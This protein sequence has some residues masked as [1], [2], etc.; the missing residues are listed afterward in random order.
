MKLNLSNLYVNAF[1]L[2]F[3]CMLHSANL[4][5]QTPPQLAFPIDCKLNEDCFII[6]YVDTNSAQDVHEDFTCGHKTTPQHKG[7]DIALSNRVNM[8]AGVNILAALDGKVLRLRDGQDDAPKTEEQYQAIRDTNKDC[9]NG[10]ILDHGNGLQTYYCHLKQGSIQVEQNQEV[11]QGEPIGQ[12]GQS[13]YAEFPHLHFTVIWEGGHIDPFTGHLKDAGCG[14]F[15]NNLWKENLTYDAYS[16][17]DGGF[18]NSVP[19]FETIQIGEENPKTLPQNSKAIVYW[20]G[21]YHAHEGDEISLA[22]YDPN[23]EIIAQKNETLQTSRKEPSYRYIGKKLRK[24]LTP[25]N[26]KGAITYRKKGYPEKTVT[27]IVTVN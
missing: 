26:Y 23:G 12:I 8:K 4:Y 13:G 15:K 2:F 18:R 16:I 14:R 7:T 25:G 3:C 22:L 19:N 6:N 5:A 27:H 21:F 11:K 20:A 17:F 1:L 24:P 9:G 10:V